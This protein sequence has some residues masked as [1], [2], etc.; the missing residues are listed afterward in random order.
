MHGPP[1]VTGPAP[2]LG[3]NTPTALDALP[4]EGSDRTVDA[5]SGPVRQNQAAERPLAGV[6]VIDFTNAVA[7]PIASFLL[8]DLGAD[9]IKVEA[10]NGRPLHAAGTAPLRE[11]CEDRSYDR[12]MLFNE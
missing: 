1:W 10:P 8:G 12:V 6:R 9:V 7:G 2:M 11:G 3:R 4:A 5:A